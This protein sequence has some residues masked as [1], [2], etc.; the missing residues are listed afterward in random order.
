M[1][2]RAYGINWL[3]AAVNDI[4]GSQLIA[5][6]P[7]DAHLISNGVDEYIIKADEQDEANIQQIAAENL[8]FMASDGQMLA[9]YITAKDEQCSVVI[10]PDDNS[11]FGVGTITAEDGIENHS[12]SESRF[13][14]FGDTSPQIV[15]EEV[16][17]DD[18]VQRQGEEFVEIPAEQ[19]IGSASQVLL[20]IEVP[21]PTAQDEYTTMRPYPCDFCSR[22]F[23][24]KITLMNHM[25]THQSDRSL[26]CKLCNTRFL[27][28]TDL[29]NHLKSHAY[30][31]ATSYEGTNFVNFT[32]RKHEKQENVNDHF[33]NNDWESHSNIAITKKTLPQSQNTSAN[34][35]LISAPLRGRVSRLKLSDNRYTLTETK[36]DHGGDIQ[37][38]EGQE[39]EHSPT[40]NTLTTDPTEHQFQFPII[41]ESKPFVCQQCGLAFARE[42]ALLSHTKNHQKDTA[43][44][45]NQCNEIFWDA[46][47]LQEHMKT[48]QFEESNSEYD[49]ADGD[50][51]QSDSESE[52]AYGEFYCNECGLAF[53]RK[54]LLNRHKKLHEGSNKTKMNGEDGNKSEHH[55][56]CTTCGETF[57]EALDLL[58]HA[59]VHARY[60]PFKCLL[61]GE[62][63]IEEITI[64]RHIET[65][66]SGE[67]TQNSCILCGKECRDRKALMKHSWDHSREKCHSCSKCGKSFYSKARLRRHMASHRDKTVSCD[68]CHEEFPDGRTLSNHRHSHSVNSTGKLFPCN[69]C[70]KTFG[71]RSSQQIHVRIHT[72][73]RPYGCRF[74]WK[75]FAD[76]GTLRKHER[77][78]TG[79]KPYACSVCP[80]AFNQRVVLREHIRSHHSGLDTKRGVYFCT[81]CSEQ[82][83]SSGDLMQHLIEHSDK[84]TAMQRQPIVGPRKYKRRRKLKPHELEHMRE[85]SF[86][87]SDIDISDIDMDNM[88]DILNI[89]ESETSKS[90]NAKKFKYSKS[91]SSTISSNLQ[92][93]PGSANKKD[94]IDI[95]ERKVRK[96]NSSVSSSDK[97]WQ[98]KLINS[99]TKSEAYKSMLSN[100]E[101]T[102]QT[103][104]TLVV[105]Y[106]KANSDTS[107]EEFRLKLPNKRTNSSECIAQRTQQVKFDK[108]GNKYGNDTVLTTPNKTRNRKRTEKVS[109]NIRPKMIHTEKQRVNKA[110]NHKKRAKTFITRTDTNKTNKTNVEMQ[111]ELYI[112]SNNIEPLNQINPSAIVIKEER[113]TDKSEHYAEQYVCP[114]QIQQSSRNLYD[115]QLLL[116]AAALRKDVYEKF[117]PSVV[118][119]LEDILRSPLKSE[120]TERQRFTSE[121]STH[122]LADQTE[123]HLQ[124][125]IKIETS[126]PELRDMYP[127]SSS[128][129]VSVANDMQH[130]SKGERRS[131][132]SRLTT[133]NRKFLDFETELLNKPSSSSQKR[134]V[135]QN[136]NKPIK[137]QREKLNSTQ[138]SF[139]DYN[140][141]NNLN[142]SS[143]SNSTY[144]PMS[145]VI[146]S[147]NQTTETTPTKIEQK[148]FF[149]CEMCSLVFSDRAQ[150]LGHVPI[151]I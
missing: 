96:R 121:S 59:E 131:T 58:A 40:T 85:K 67:M 36:P 4:K 77:I 136:K 33:Y 76:G 92:D 123:L 69:E 99:T 26:L 91:N 106:D 50:L 42:K 52:H 83:P 105:D 27:K 35:S 140:N 10:S 54:N 108:G 13:I 90:C 8:I 100:V 37:L 63:F 110:D 28:R 49:P 126:S 43:N 2:G 112:L 129:S 120:R 101:N 146:N 48:H 111:D 47:S 11:A 124:N 56:C 102:L 23:R 12:D 38:V 118:N 144:S 45:C 141:Y 133:V 114:D 81:V 22:R 5:M 41:D 132:R 78:H 61:C 89:N 151:H 147:I 145:A 134:E 139:L 62:S 88:Q 149:E 84:N 148:R 21:L 75:A 1:E 150:L 82:L 98:T 137:S 94:N 60:P 57:A 116:E 117:N 70:G 93:A 86:N 25:V 51:T 95:N 20:D 125:Y 97:N 72:G 64:K 115:A 16:I 107:D 103:I 32:T 39:L 73:E 71:S 31:D 142:T 109:K 18:W 119:D 6:Q 44:E 30:D 19:L 130:H 87:E 65:K 79:E 138:N 104:D 68:V 3:T 128:G 34:S 143:S 17:T 53:H 9:E 29:I 127:S 122:Y 14:D 46:N 135:T 80:R 74:C 113:Q 66:H 7:E 15:T 24:K 55:C